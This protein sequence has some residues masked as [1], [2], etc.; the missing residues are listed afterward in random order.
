MLCN[1][2]GNHGAYGNGV[3]GSQ[4]EEKG[5]H[6]QDIYLFDDN[7]ENNGRTKEILNSFVIM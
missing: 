1:K 4:C 2:N 5:Y 7:M 6:V 3:D